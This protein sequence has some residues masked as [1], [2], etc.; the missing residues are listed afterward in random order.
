MVIAPAL[1]ITTQLQPFNLLYPSSHLFIIN[2][3]SN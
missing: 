2:V 1:G 3:R